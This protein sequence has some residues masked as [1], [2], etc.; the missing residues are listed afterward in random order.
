VREVEQRRRE[1]KN[2][3]SCEKDWPNKQHVDGYVDWVSVISAIESK[4]V[5][6]VK[7]SDLSHC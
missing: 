3:K 6:K 2:K 7:Y 5:L 4:L 1:V